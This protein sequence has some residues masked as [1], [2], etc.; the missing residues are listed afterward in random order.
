MYEKVYVKVL[1]YGLDVPE[2]DITAL[3]DQPEILADKFDDED[4]PRGDIL[5]RAMGMTTHPTIAHGD[6]QSY[7]YVDSP[8]AKNSY[9]FIKDNPVGHSIDFSVSDTKY[10]ATKAHHVFAVWSPSYNHHLNLIKKLGYSFAWGMFT[11][12]EILA[13][14][15]KFSD[16]D[17]EGIKDLI[18]QHWPHLKP[19][20]T[21]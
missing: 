11:P 17:R 9:Y 19:Q 12:E 18:Y 2:K 3:I 13:M 4:D 6:T 1:R 21:E 20:A 7:A 8:T 15:H 16:Q 5:R 10:P 14:S